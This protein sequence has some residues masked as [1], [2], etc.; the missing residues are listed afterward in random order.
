MP[1]IDRKMS[2]WKSRLWENAVQT[3]LNLTYPIN[4][5]QMLSILTAPIAYF[6]AL[7]QIFLSQI[8]DEER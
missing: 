1:V 3:Q 6:N 5:N 8:F 7:Y 4:L 2:L